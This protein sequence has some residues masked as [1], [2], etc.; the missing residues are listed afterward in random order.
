MDL[1]NGSMVSK[2]H[3]T[4]ANSTNHNIFEKEYCGPSIVFTAREFVV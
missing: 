4:A 2:G 1:S 3:H